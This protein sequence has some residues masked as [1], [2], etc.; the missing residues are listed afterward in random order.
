MFFFAL[1]AGFDLQ[2]LPD[3]AVPAVVLAGVMLVVKPWVFRAILTWEG[4]APK[5]SAEVGLRLGQLS[6]FSLLI[7]ALAHNVAIVGDRATYVIQAATLISFVISSYLIMLRY[8][9]PIA[10]SASL[11]RD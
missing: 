8:P 7:A 2:V 11:R 5:L 4:E 1:G 9:T 6:E 10:V 3:V